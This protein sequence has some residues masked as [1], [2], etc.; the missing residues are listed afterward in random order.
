MREIMI[1]NIL[2]LVFM[3]PVLFVMYFILKGEA[4]EK[5]GVYFGLHAPGEEEA[6]EQ[7]L[8]LVQEQE[9]IYRKRM[10]RSL[11]WLALIPF[12]TFFIP[13]LSIGFTIWMLWLLAVIA[14][15]ELPFIQANRVLSAWKKEHTIREKSGERYAEIKQAGRIRKVRLFQFAPFI[16]IS[17]LTGIV[18]SV[19]FR[20]TRI[21][22]MSLLVDTFALTTLLFYLIAVWTDR[23]KVAVISMNSEINLNFARARKNCWK[24]FCLACSA[25]NTLI[26]ILLAVCLGIAGVS[27]SVVLIIAVIYSFLLFG[28]VFRTL[29]KVRRL[30]ADYMDSAEPLVME[31]DDEHWIWGMFYY[32]KQDKHTMVEK[33]YGIGT[34][35]NMATPAGMGMNV[36]GCAALLVIPIMCIW[37]IFLEFTPINLSIR[38]QLLVAE[39]LKTDYEIPVA[40][41]ENLELIGKL[42]N[43]SKNKGTGMENLY[44]GEFHEAGTGECEVFLNPQNELFLSFTAGDTRYYMS[45]AED[46]ATREIYEQLQELLSFQIM[47]E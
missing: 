28:V 33:R 19:H 32:N 40:E 46:E 22:T 35:M 15:L 47:Q 39:Q 30:E 18:F 14:F 31:D 5:R 24:N 43:L 23:Q 6:K 10:K 34:T 36:I 25:V 42:P 2:L 8:V 44:K 26:T 20:G 4:Q 17:L 13:S 37:M 16:V 21:G 3:Y 7:F 11:L 38:D 27:V 41:I 45:A 9:V 1:L 12:V 29:K